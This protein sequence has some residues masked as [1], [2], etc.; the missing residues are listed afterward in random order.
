MIEKPIDIFWFDKTR[1]KCMTEGRNINELRRLL[2]NRDGMKCSLCNKEFDHFGQL[3]VEHKIPVE[4]GGKI[5]CLTNLDFACIKCHRKK[6]D[7]D[8]RVIKIIKDSGIIV[9]G[10]RES[11]YKLEEIGKIYSYWFNIIKDCKERHEIWYYGTPKVDFIQ[12]HDLSNRE[13]LE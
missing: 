3:E 1:N 5:F 12:K 6:T 10:L 9:K 7:I 11:F 8:K 2:K 4:I 13:V